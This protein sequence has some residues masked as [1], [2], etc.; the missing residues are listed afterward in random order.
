MNERSRL[1]GIGDLKRTSEI[2]KTLTSDEVKR[3]FRTQSSDRVLKRKEEKRKMGSVDD[4]FQKSYESPEGTTV[5]RTVNLEFL[6]FVWV[7]ILSFVLFV[8][9]FFS[10]LKIKFGA[11]LF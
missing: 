9:S 11:C 1:K 3:R 8:F 2:F 5:K 6:C 4:L 7:L 10:F